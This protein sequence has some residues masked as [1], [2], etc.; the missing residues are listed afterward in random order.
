MNENR[1]FANEG[2]RTRANVHGRWTKFFCL[3][4]FFSILLIGV[5]GAQPA[6]VPGKVPVVAS[7]SA[8]ST[9]VQAPDEVVSLLDG[10]E[11]NPN[12]QDK[13]WEEQQAVLI[14]IN[15]LLAGKVSSERGLKRLVGI[16][17]TAKEQVQD[18]IERLE[19]ELKK[20]VDASKVPELPVLDGGGVVDGGKIV[21]GRPI[22]VAKDGGKRSSVPDAGTA[23]VPVDAGAEAGVDG[24]VKR[25]TF[26]EL[27]ALRVDVIKTTLTLLKLPIA[28]RTEI[29]ERQKAWEQQLEEEKRKDEE[30]KQSEEAAQRAEHDRQKAIKAAEE[31][32]TAIGRTIAQ[33]RVKIEEFSLSQIKFQH[34]LTVKKAELAKRTAA[35]QK[36]TTQ[37]I[38]DA[39]VV[40]PKDPST[41]ALYNKIV[42]EL[43]AQRKVIELNIEW[44]RNVPLSPKLEAEPQIPEVKDPELI[45]QRGELLERYKNLKSQEDLMNKSAREMAWEELQDSVNQ[46]AELN[47]VRLTILQNVTE[48][49]RNAVLG[50]GREGIEQLIE[51]VNHIR[52]AGTWT[53]VA[54]RRLV[55]A[56]LNSMIR[57][58]FVLWSIFTHVSLFFALLYAGGWV[59]RR[60]GTWL[61]QLQDVASD[62]RKI[63]VLLRPLLALIPAVRSVHKELIVVM[64]IRF[65]PY[66]T[67]IAR[68]TGLFGVLYSLAIWYFGYKLALASTHRSLE[69]LTT[70]GG[71][72]ID[73]P[74][75]EKLLRS[76][77]LV[78][79]YS[80]WVATIIIGS[81]AL[82]GQGYLYHL[83]ARF[84]WIGAIPI[85]IVL[86][87]WWRNDIADGYL[88]FR[89]TGALAE[90]VERSRNRW[91]GFV[92]TLAAFA[93]ISVVGA[94]RA[95]R[96]F[97]MGFEQTRKALAYLFRRRLERQASSTPSQDGVIELPEPIVKIFNN[98]P[99]VD[100]P[101]LVDH[102]PK[103]DLFEKQV[104][105][106]LATSGPAAWLIVGQRGCGKT[107]WLNQARRHLHEEL[108]IHTLTLT[109]R[110]MDVKEWL[111]WLADIVGA[112][113]SATQSTQ[114][115]DTWLES[116]PKRL[117]IIDN[118]HFLYL[119]SVEAGEPIKSLCRL[120]ESTQRHIFWLCTVST[121][122]FHFLKWSKMIGDSFRKEVEL[123]PWSEEDISTLIEVRNEK[124]GLKVSYDNLLI[125]KLEDSDLQTQ[126]VNTARDYNRLIWD[127]S[128]GSPGVA[129]LC[130]KSSLI[131][132]KNE[133]EESH[134]R[135]FPKPDPMILDSLSEEQ[136]F[137][138]ADIVWHGCLSLDHITRSSLFRI[139]ICEN[140][141]ITLFDMGVLQ[142]TEYGY[143]VTNEWWPNVVWYLRRRHLLED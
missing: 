72:K 62:N 108:P 64:T 95:A 101:Y 33:E 48:A 92:I 93:V 94:G 63:P 110:T 113:M 126:S 127:Y 142:Q 3:V 139:T 107:S 43:V 89:S 134:I 140:T 84:A 14:G 136:I 81:A 83:V 18:T 135:L 36:K 123:Q 90:T 117:I 66:A 131:P 120:I 106:W 86:M 11:N 102:F 49:K 111:K 112:P 77:R 23:T 133:E 35:R 15:Q 46:E 118:V 121:Y 80:F 58:P 88:R 75:S 98:E 54:G 114:N 25:P 31:A 141:M 10:L 47:R 115:M 85:A 125:E 20:L 143:E 128:N 19:K 119:R 67:G 9:V 1:W 73:E 96:T 138:L 59:R 42:E 4:L 8:S 100:Q 41:D 30:R 6:L 60:A 69:W 28:K 130:W 51:E 13:L 21:P 137:I 26:A 109:K 99:I 78:G 87:R 56:K 79:R 105:S 70:V 97:V 12:E 103:L 68:G 17:L 57:D 37:L 116:G 91:Y 22:P 61:E 5:A 74:R 2:V 124:V 122:P 55:I 132:S 7:A 34:T 129:L 27:R 44:Y 104:R 82:V 76:V 65:I 71:G 45:K 32:K 50:F 40:K 24:G 52:L 39:K 16:D 53:L 29:A 38:N